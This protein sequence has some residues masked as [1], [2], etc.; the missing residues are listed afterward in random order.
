MIEDS[1]IIVAQAFA[2]L[3]LGYD[4]FLSQRVVSRINAY[5]DSRTESGRTDAVGELHSQMTTFQKLLPLFIGVLLLFAVFGSATLVAGA[6]PIDLSGI[7]GL[8]IML[9]L[10]FGLFVSLSALAMFLVIAALVTTRPLIV[11]GLTSVLIFG[12]RGVLGA[13]GMLVLLLSFVFAYNNATVA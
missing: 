9:F 8:V 6:L 3:L 7:W 11:A 1:T 4:Y 10:A 5:V 12:S 13:V 2:S